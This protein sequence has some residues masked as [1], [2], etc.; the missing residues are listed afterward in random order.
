MSLLSQDWWEKGTGWGGVGG[1]LSTAL[2]QY[3]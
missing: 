3:L 1:D 2:P